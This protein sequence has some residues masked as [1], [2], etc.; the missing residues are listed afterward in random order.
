MLGSGGKF[1]GRFVFKGGAEMKT[2]FVLYK[3]ELL[4]FWRSSKWIW[5]PIVFAIL[6]VMQP[7]SMY[8]MPE[9]LKATGGLPEG[10]VFEFPTPSGAE[11]MAGVLSQYGTIG[12]VI[13]VA[14]V[15]GTIQ[16]E[17][18]RGT[19]SLVMS[20]PV[21]GLQFLLGKW[22]AELTILLVSLLFGYGL[23]FYYTN[24]LFDPVSLELFIKSFL[25][26]FVWVCFMMT[27]TL[28]GS[29]LFKSTGAVMGSSI[30]II[31][32]LSLLDGYFEKFMKWS[33]SLLSTQASMILTE[34]R[35]FRFLAFNLTCSIV[36]IVLL[37]I[38]ATVVFERQERF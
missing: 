8:Y 14:A 2:W 17:R 12:V 31:A 23:S 30:V 33:P 15:M 5:L 7:L 27:V 6:G 10:A 25:L 32:L 13:I 18:Q 9:I 28:I 20:R 38:T 21:S 34:G 1:I 29:M 22:T 24:L 19:M 36:I 35:V 26:Y 11:V 16:S 37:F 3:K 4:S